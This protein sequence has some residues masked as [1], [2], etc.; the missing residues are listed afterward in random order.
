MPKLVIIMPPSG[1][2]F[3]HANN[4]SSGSSG[5]L[6]ALNGVGS[7]VAWY[8]SGRSAS[9]VLAWSDRTLSYY[10]DNDAKVQL[11]SDGSAY[12]YLAFG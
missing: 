12:R 1:V 9:V 8:L 10:S 2:G 6:I 3:T 5:G 11:N 7:F 4:N